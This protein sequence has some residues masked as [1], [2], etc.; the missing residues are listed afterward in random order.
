MKHNHRYPHIHLRFRKSPNGAEHSE[1]LAIPG[2]RWRARGYYVVPHHALQLVQ[3][4]IKAFGLRISTAQW[5]VEEAPSRLW[6]SW[7]AHLKQQGE[8]RDF[9]LDGFLTAYQCEAIQ[10]MG[11]RVGAHFWHSTG[12]GKTLTAILWGLLQPGPIVIVTRAASRLQQGREVERFTHLRPFV[13]RPITSKKQK[14]LDQYL[15]EIDHRPIVILGWESLTFHIDALEKIPPASVV[16]DESHRG[17][18]PKRWQAVPLP[19][20]A[21]N[22]PKEQAKFYGK[23]QSDAKRRGGFIP[24]EG[25]SRHQGPDLG[26]VM[27]VPTENITSAAARLSRV[28]QRVCATT[29]TPIKDRVRD[30]WAQLDLVEP[31]AWGSASIWMHRYTDA[32]PGKFGGMDTRGSSNLEELALRLSPVAH[33]VDYKET[34]R[35]LP[36]K[37]RQSVYIAPEDQC[38]PTA[39]FPKEMKAAAKRGPGAVLEVK[40]AQAASKKERAVMGLIEDHISSGH[41]VTIFTG[42]RRDVDRMGER[43]EKLPLVKKKNVKIWTAHGGNTATARQG[44]VDEYMQSKGP[45]ILV[46]TGQSLGESMNLQDTDAALF[47]QLPYTP[48]E[49]VQWEGRFA[50][51]GQQRPVCIYYLIAEDTVDE[52]VADILINK[53][54]AVEQVSEDGAL[55]DAKRILGGIDDEDKIFDSILSKME[56]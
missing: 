46:A 50:R 9:V 49:L 14:T 33:R 45:C 22:D 19:D 35:H 53:L 34:H 39:G 2:I 16:F 11:H 15:E 43:I 28:A 42:R 51:L 10:V 56:E 52:H 1:I 41:K 23:Q 37:R 8:M 55:E 31:Y 38:R 12:A 4:L 26:R 44:I 17:K 6:D 32:K 27:I 29:A 7:Q 36:A 5:A 13:V 30:L 54:S 25:E 48:G 40:I 21:S 18:S 24:K 47:V 3:R 20:C